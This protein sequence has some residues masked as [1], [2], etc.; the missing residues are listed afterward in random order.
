MRPSRQGS[1]SLQSTA[2]KS[3]ASSY[4]I[5][6]PPSMLGLSKRPKGKRRKK[7]RRR[8][9]PRVTRMLSKRQQ[10]LMLPAAGLVA[11]CHLTMT[12]CCPAPRAKEK[13]AKGRAAAVAKWVPCCA[14]AVWHRPKARP[15]MLLKNSRL[16]KRFLV[17]FPLFS[18]I[19][20]ERGMKSATWRDEKTCHIASRLIIVKA[21]TEKGYPILPVGWGHVWLLCCECE[22]WS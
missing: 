22:F 1:M 7:R 15:M 2:T 3:S 8:V 11:A 17:F 12:P 18:C 5:S 4:T 14:R 13:C 10:R 21:D 19:R 6:S 20:G 16:C 9:L